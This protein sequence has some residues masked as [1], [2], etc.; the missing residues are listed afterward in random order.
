MI[1]SA[2]PLLL[3]AA[4]G[5]VHNDP[6]RTTSPAPGKCVVGQ[7]DRLVGKM[8]SDAVEVEAKT[9]SGAQS[10]RWIAPGDMVTKD[11][12]EERLDLEVDE[13]GKVIRAYCG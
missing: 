3:L 6:P 2:L 11:Y 12:R 7:L 13:G 4:G 8:R 5:C 1:R 10:V 9:W